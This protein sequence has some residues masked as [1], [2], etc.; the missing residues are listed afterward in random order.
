MDWIKSN[1]LDPS[2]VGELAKMGWNGGL[3]CTIYSDEILEEVRKVVEDEVTHEQILKICCDTFKAEERQRHGGKGND[4]EEGQKNIRELIF[5]QDV[6]LR[7]EERREQKRKGAIIRSG[8]GFPCIY[9]PDFETKYQEEYEGHV[10]TK[11]PD[12]LPCPTDEE[13]DLNGDRIRRSRR[14]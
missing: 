1:I 8:Q 9:C 12:H 10:L 6:V 11:H 13:L 2:L 14:K 3:Q 5:R 7:I 4:C